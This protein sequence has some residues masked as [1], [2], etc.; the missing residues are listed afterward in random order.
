M[1][2]NNFSSKIYEYIVIVQQNREKLIK[3]NFKQQKN[4][5]NL[6]I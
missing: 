4:K 2:K 6:K 5:T 1:Q 3:Q